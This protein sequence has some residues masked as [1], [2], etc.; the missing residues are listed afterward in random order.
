MHGLSQRFRRRQ[1]GE[2]AK[3]AD[4]ASLRRRN[5]ENYEKEDESSTGLIQVKYSL[6]E[7]MTWAKIQKFLEEKFPKS[8]YPKLSFEEERV[9]SPSAVCAY[10]RLTR[11]QVDRV[12]DK[13]IFEIPR[14]F[15]QVRTP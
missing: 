9:S 15:M 7:G 2:T 10:R 8:E 5:T 6:Y 14:K 3:Q 11:S 1:T 4:A 12:S 13:W